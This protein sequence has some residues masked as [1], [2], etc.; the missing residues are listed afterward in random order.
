[1]LSNAMQNR[2]MRVAATHLSS[3]AHAQNCTVCV[4]LHCVALCM[5]SDTLAYKAT[6]VST[7]AVAWDHASACT[8]QLKVNLCLTRTA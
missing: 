2:H 5:D 8:A 4:V 6:Q 1:M 7:V 3:E